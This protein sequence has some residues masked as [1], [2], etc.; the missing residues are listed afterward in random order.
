MAFWKWCFKNGFFKMTFQKWHFENDVLK[1]TF[2]KVAFEMLQKVPFDKWHFM[3]WHFENDV[4]K[5]T[6]EFFIVF[7]MTFRKRTIH[8]FAHETVEMI[9][10]QSFQKRHFEKWHFTKCSSQECHLGNRHFELGQLDNDSFVRCQNF[11]LSRLSI[12]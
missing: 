3:K 6:I 11:N 1:M 7:K 8:F 9:P 2:Q 10:S 5:T 4:S 12:F